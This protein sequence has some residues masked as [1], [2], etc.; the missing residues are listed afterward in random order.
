MRHRT[1]LFVISTIVLALVASI[2]T[3]CVLMLRSAQPVDRLVG[4]WK[5]EG[6]GPAKMNMNFGENTGV[7]NSGK[8]D[9]TLT[10][11]TSVQ[12]TFNRDG[13]MTMSWRSE[14]DGLRLSFDVPDPKKPGDIGRWAVVRT[15]GDAVVIRMGDPEHPDSPEWKVV[16]RGRDEF[17]ATPVDTSNGTDPLQF[18][19]VK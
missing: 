8:F 4:S 12:A 10:V 19:R 7:G 17:V 16:F 11:R 18:R 3:A 14:G 1:R 13:T 5:G 6:T 15:D 2:I 9:A